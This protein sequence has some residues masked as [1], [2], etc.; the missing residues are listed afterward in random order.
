VPAAT[1]KRRPEEPNTIQ[2][3]G[4]Q[5]DQ[6]VHLLLDSIIIHALHE[7]EKADYNQ[8]TNRHANLE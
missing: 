7:G 1:K 5:F 6:S 8:M 2:P 4:N 3:L